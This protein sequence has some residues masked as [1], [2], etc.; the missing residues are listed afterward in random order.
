M[1]RKYGLQKLVKPIWKELKHI[2]ATASWVMVEYV[3]S[4][5]EVLFV[6]VAGLS[7]FLSNTTV[8]ALFVNIVYPLTPLS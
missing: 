1:D 2:F 6:V 4:I 8:V 5:S 3:L 7:S